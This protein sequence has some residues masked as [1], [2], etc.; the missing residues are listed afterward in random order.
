MYKM[1]GWVMRS[2][3]LTVVLSLVLLAVSVGWAVRLTSQQGVARE[4]SRLQG[5]GVRLKLSEFRPHSVVPASN[6][7][8]FYL[9]AVELSEPDRLLEE[10]SENLE[11]T[12]STRASDARKLIDDRSVVFTLLAKGYE[13]P[14][15]S[16][17][18]RIE[19]GFRMHVPNYV[20]CRSLARTA[21]VRAQ[22]EVLDGNPQ[23]AVRTTAWTLHFIDR[24]HY[25]NSL[26]HH[27]ITLACYKSVFPVLESMAE[28]GVRTD[29]SAV[30][31]EL[32]TIRGQQ[33]TAMQECIEV[34]RAL[35]VDMFDRIIRGEDSLPELLKSTLGGTEMTARWRTY[36]AAGT[37]A[38]LQDE[39]ALLGAYRQ[40]D[41]ALKAGNPDLM[42]DV[43]SL[44]SWALL[45]QMIIPNCKKAWENDRKV[46]ERVEQLIR[47]LE[48]LQA[49]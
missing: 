14:E 26:I 36:M 1:L 33:A 4:L 48:A 28:R 16:F 19:D 24:F 22:L 10:A 20:R 6:A 40:M 43:A 3:G 15:C 37:P 18:Y 29:Y 30:L 31:K 49:N 21:A 44:P 32:N 47:R 8:A 46:T 11:K 12:V 42:P 38:V 23:D 5:E 13:R 7:A 27:M 17:E 39:L 25:P 45:S 35:A 34:E 9:A 2:R 41:V